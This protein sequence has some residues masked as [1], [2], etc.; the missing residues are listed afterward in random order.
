MPGRWAIVSLCRCRAEPFA[1]NLSL[2]DVAAANSFQPKR[3][4][5]GLQRKKPPAGGFSF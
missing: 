5:R 2:S 3:I 4:R 1:G